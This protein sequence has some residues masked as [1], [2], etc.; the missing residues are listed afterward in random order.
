MAEKKDEAVTRFGLRR[1]LP[2]LLILGGGTGARPLNRA[3]QN[4][5]PLLLPQCN[6]IHVTG[7]RFE[8]TAQ[9]VPGYFSV[10]F[11]DESLDSAYAASDIVVTRAGMG[12]LSECAHL[13][14]PTVLVPYP[15]SPQVKNAAYLVARGAALLVPQDERMARGILHACQS[16]LASRALRLQLSDHLASAVPTDD[17]SA[18]LQTINSLQD[19][20]L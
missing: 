4:V 12:V 19:L 1:S 3:I 5:A 15:N 20:S 14:L 7:K 9:G 6:I 13:K 8:G 17:G 10:P 2:T 11:L 18:V 16:L